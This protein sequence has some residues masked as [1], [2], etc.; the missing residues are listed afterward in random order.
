MENVM[1]KS[2][3]L[4][5]LPCPSVSLLPLS[6]HWQ[7]FEDRPCLTSGPM[8]RTKPGTEEQGHFPLLLHVHSAILL[9]LYGSPI[10]LLTSASGWF[11]QGDIPAWD[12]RKEGEHSQSIHHHSFLFAR[13]TDLTSS[14]TE[15][16]APHLYLPPLHDA[17]HPDSL[18]ST[19]Y[20]LPFP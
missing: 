6:H 11:H 9:Y 17:Q 13:L 20:S 1:R 2:M 3:P 10:A 15:S 19:S 14:P 8:L 16:S 7:L 18:S 12:Q 5:Q 4:S